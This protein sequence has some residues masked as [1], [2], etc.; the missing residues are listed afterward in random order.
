MSKQPKS[1][2]RIGD[3]MATY[4]GGRFWPFDP[5]PEEVKI[6]DIAH[7]LSL[8]NRFNG[9]TKLAY[10]VACH[11]YWVSIFCDPRDAMNGL[12]H[13]AHEAY[14]GDWIS[15][16]KRHEMF[17]PLKLAASVVQVAVAKRFGVQAAKTA[18]VE[19]VDHLMF[20]LE[21]KQMMRPERFIAGAR[22]EDLWKTY[23]PEK[24]HG[25]PMADFTI[26]VWSAEF[27]EHKFL[28]R[29]HELDSLR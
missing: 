17:D 14:F 9:A 12:L 1:A 26:P 8:V 21:A 23:R 22:R 18:S 10:N 29:F 15:P 24:L 3:W 25:T 16:I 27:S 11:S 20:Q 4:S 19:R 2:E 6:E 28:Q 5:R 7:H 13:D